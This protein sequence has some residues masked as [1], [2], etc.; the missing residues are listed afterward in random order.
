MWGKKT[1]FL[2][3]EVESWQI[4]CWRW[5]LKSELISTSFDQTPLVLP[6]QDFFP[7]VSQAGHE[8]AMAIFDAV[9]RHAD[10]ADWPVKLVQQ[11]DVPAFL[12]GGAFLEHETSCAGTFRCGEGQDPIIT[13]AP[14]QLSN[15][16]SLIA[17]F[18]HELGHYVNGYFETE[19]PGGW[20]L[21]EPATDVT[22][23]A[24]GFGLFIANNS[25]V[26]EVD[27]Q[28]FRV[29]KVG[30]LSEAERLFSLALFMLLR[31][32]D[33]HDAEPYLKKHQFRSLRKA[34][35]SIGER[36]LHQPLQ[37]MIQ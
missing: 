23:I 7:A 13:Y 31:G 10:V 25:I 19:P 30:Y 6:N 5:H 15:P 22:A 21:L 4:E 16:M 27:E 34:V 9:K 8:R 2:P 11:D 18:S 20:D 33:L 26:H 37:E 1:N 17:T 35:N 28:G 29:G 24:L 12:P 3:N 14:D 36:G 32:F